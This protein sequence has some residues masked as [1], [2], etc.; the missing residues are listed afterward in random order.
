VQDWTEFGLRS[1]P[2]MSAR[3]RVTHVPELQHLIDGVLRQADAELAAPM[4]GITADGHVV[5]GLFGKSGIKVDA[6][7]IRRAA[8]AFADSLDRAH[9]E[10][11]LLPLNSP[12]W[13]TWFNVHMDF[14]RHGVPLD[15][16]DGGQRELGLDLIKATLSAGGYEQ[17]RKI[18]RVNELL[19]VLTGSTEE[20][21]EWLYNLSI[22]GSPSESEP[23]GWQ[24]DGHH[25]TIN[26][27]I[28]DGEISLTPMF[29]GSEPC[30][31]TSSHAASVKAG[32]F[33]YVDID[34]YVGI[35]LFGAEEQAG[36]DIIQSLDDE[37]R[38]V[39]TM[40]SSIMP[41]TLPKHLEHWIDGRMQAGP[42]KDNLVLPYQGLRGDAM[43]VPQRAQLLSAV[44]IYLDWARQDHAAA[45]MAEASDH[46]HETWF[47]W[48][49]GTGRD[50]PFYY[51]IQSPV[52]LIEFD[53]HPGIVFD[54][55]E[56]SRNHI[57]MIMRSPNGGDYGA[58]LLARHYA[59][60]DHGTQA[61][62]HG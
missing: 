26:C 49:G 2:V 53:H 25:L 42:F 32:Q 13:R 58:D 34:P 6:V 28:V 17:V 55:I 35:D 11:L 40:Y 52:V 43:T 47:T 50:D 20:F 31:V 51:R 7:P 45:R 8:T 39:A 21:G 56:P 19:A 3:S 4:T 18:M 48:F 15:D 22:F 5:P 30:K 36:T 16:L 29:M 62:G 44:R 38:Q 24:I 1:A 57:H 23:W 60:F 59:K 37:Q 27:V 41:G 9:R 61:Q 33:H 46:L 12:D 54:N 14:F 10:K